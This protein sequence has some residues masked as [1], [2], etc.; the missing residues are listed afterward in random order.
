MIVQNK[1]I[2]LGNAAPMAFYSNAAIIPFAYNT[3]PAFWKRTN[4]L[5]VN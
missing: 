5:P 3:L 1:K 4:W 2:E